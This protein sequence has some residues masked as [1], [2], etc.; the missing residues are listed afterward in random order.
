MQ[1][2]RIGRFNASAQDFIDWVERWETWYE[3]LVEEMIENE[4][5]PLF[6]SYE[7]MSIQFL[8]M[9]KMHALLLYHH[10]QLSIDFQ[11]NLVNAPQKRELGCS[12]WSVQN[13]KYFKE[14]VESKLSGKAYTSVSLC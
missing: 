10:L 14:E 7:T 8:R 5:N 13:Y 1:T 11:F 2:T 9:E 4:L 6:L 12:S 3:F